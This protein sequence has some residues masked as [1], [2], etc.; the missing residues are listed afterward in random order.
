MATNRATRQNPNPGVNPS[1]EADA[2]PPANPP[3]AQT[4]SSAFPYE[5]GMRAFQSQITTLTEVVSALRIAAQPLLE[6]AA[7]TA[8]HQAPAATAATA[9]TA[10]HPPTPAQ[11]GGLRPYPPMP[12]QPVETLIGPTLPKHRQAFR[13]LRN[14]V[15]AFYEEHT[16]A[17]ASPSRIIIVNATLRAGLKDFFLK[18][19][20][21][22]LAHILEENPDS[23]DDALTA[24]EKVFPWPETCADQ[25]KPWPGFLESLQHP[26]ANIVELAVMIRGYINDI[27]S[28]QLYDKPPNDPGIPAVARGATMQILGDLERSITANPSLSARVTEKISSEEDKMSYS[29]KTLLNWAITAS[30]MTDAVG[31]AHA[32]YKKRTQPKPPDKPN[33]KSEGSDPPKDAASTPPPPQ[34]PSNSNSA[35]N[36]GNKKDKGAPK[37]A[38]NHSV[39]NAVTVAP[40]ETRASPGR[41]RKHHRHPVDSKWQALPLE[42]K[43][44]LVRVDSD[45][46]GKARGGLATYFRGRTVIGQHPVFGLAQVLKKKGPHRTSCPEPGD[47]IR[48]D[49]TRN[50]EFGNYTASKFSRASAPAVLPRPP[51]PQ[52]RLPRPRSSTAWLR[53][54]QATALYVEVSLTVDTG[55]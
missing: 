23:I 25:T 21:P 28:Y 55:S 50:D 3:V 2:P 46:S 30:N 32:S 11:G 51:R 10:P 48:V 47:F 44:V 4:P 49:A 1:Q 27:Y 26:T 8:P 20:R 5:D 42:V 16:S 52:Q 15:K 14:V 22:D 35:T 43:D 17:P 34:A 53:T 37:Q 33:G 29:V 31:R 6:T 38:Q 45:N 18:N 19:A 40:A 39:A 12:L 9:P 24:I 13:A 54:R 41:P 36:N 7:A